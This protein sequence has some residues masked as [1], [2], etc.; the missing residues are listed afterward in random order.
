MKITTKSDMEKNISPIN[1]MKMI[2]RKLAVKSRQHYLKPSDIAKDK[3]RKRLMTLR[4]SKSANNKGSNH[5]RSKKAA[6][7]K[8]V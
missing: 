2:S 8:E 5:T 6:N 3:E 1:M 7:N 4:S